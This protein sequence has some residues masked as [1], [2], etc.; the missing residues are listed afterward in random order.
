[1]LTIG[2][3]G[4][5]GS[6]KGEVAAVFSAAGVPTLDTDRVYHELINQDSPCVRELASAFGR[7]ILRCDGSLDRRRL[8]AIVF[9]RDDGRAARQARLNEI[10]HKYVKAVCLA[11]LA[12]EQK[13]GAPAALFDVPLLFES[14]FDRICDTTVAVIAPIETRLARI[15]IRDG[16]STEEAMARLAAQP[17]NEYYTERAAF[18]IENCGTLEELREKARALYGSIKQEWEKNNV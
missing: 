17:K 1:M 10:T 6:G 3:T 15:V 16:L 13:K 8:A 4:G 14:G 18:V 12:D 2:L 5:S 11:W 9:A 7:E